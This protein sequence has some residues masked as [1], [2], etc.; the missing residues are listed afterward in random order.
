MI[1]AWASLVWSVLALGIASWCAHDIAG[2][3]RQAEASLRRA[4]AAR[5]R[6][7]E[8]RGRAEETLKRITP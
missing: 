5:D 2:Y 1:L 8:A 6:A 7:A 4:E 3:R